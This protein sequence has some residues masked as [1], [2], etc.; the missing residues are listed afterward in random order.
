MADY[1]EVFVDIDTSKLR[2]CG[3]NCGARKLRK[4][5]AHFSREN[6]DAHPP[7]GPTEPSP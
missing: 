1:S 6:A 2:K 7:A 3:G 4:A 5:R